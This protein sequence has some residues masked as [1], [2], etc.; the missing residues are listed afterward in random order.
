MMTPGPQKR[1]SRSGV[2]ITGDRYQWLAAWSHCV[3]TLHDD[4]DNRLVAV[5]V[6][7]DDAGAL[8]DVVLY[9]SSTP[10]TF[11]QAKYAVDATSP[12]N[13]DYLCQKSR[14][15]GPSLTQ[16]FFAQHCDLREQGIANP[17]LVLLT[18]RAADPT[19]ILISGRDPRTFLLLPNAAVGTAKT[20]RGQERASWASAAELDEAELMD[21][22]TSWRFELARDTSHLEELTSLRMR[23]AGLQADDEAVRSGIDWVTRQIIAGERILNAAA[24]AAA[25]EEL[26]LKRGPTRHIVSVATLKPDPVAQ[27]AVISIDWVDRF[28]GHD[29]YAKR[30]PLAPATWPKLHEDIS[31]IPA[32]LPRSA[33]VLVTGSMRLPHGIHRRHRDADGRQYRCG[34]GPRP[35]RVEQRGAVRRNSRTHRQH[36]RGR[37]RR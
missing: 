14:A 15:G 28:D 22:L 32:A 12:V 27:D 17:D 23:A 19:D 24:I 16:K 2:R 7:V 5:G 30:R 6:E 29:A 25:I 35:R 4:S 20:Q 3:L 26:G 10:P 8:D 36:L 1:P 34:R 9:W 13:V 11:M 33:K 37:T 31:A 21:L 18:N